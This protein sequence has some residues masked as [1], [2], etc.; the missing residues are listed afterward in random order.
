[1][2]KGRLHLWS[3]RVEWRTRKLNS[4]IEGDCSRGQAALALSFGGYYYCTRLC[5]IASCREGLKTALCSPWYPFSVSQL[6]VLILVL[7]WQ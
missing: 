2:T 5:L 7:P 1:M 4:T 6:R 3:L